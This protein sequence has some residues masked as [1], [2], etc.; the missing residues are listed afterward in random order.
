[1]PHQHLLKKIKYNF[2]HTILFQKSKQIKT[3]NPLLSIVQVFKNREEAHSG[4][5]PPPMLP[6][7]TIRHRMPPQA[8]KFAV[9]AIVLSTIP[10]STTTTYAVYGW[11][12]WGLR[13]WVFRGFE[14]FS[15]AMGWWL[16]GSL[17]AC[18]DEDW[19]GD[20][21]VWW[22]PR[23]TVYLTWSIWFFSLVLNCSILVEI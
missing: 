21:R 22:Y 14:R 7:A 8:T 12:D 1:M 23:L 4:S 18:K 6:Y 10:L 5:N 16:G 15:V 13:V 2:P 3:S 17:C 9:V 19:D 11:F 20:S